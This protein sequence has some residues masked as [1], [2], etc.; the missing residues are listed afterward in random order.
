MDY[1]TQITKVVLSDSAS[2]ELSAHTY[3]RVQ[4]WLQTWTAPANFPAVLTQTLDSGIYACRRSLRDKLL[5]EFISSLGVRPDHFK[6][7]VSQQ[8][9]TNNEFWMSSRVVNCILYEVGK[10]PSYMKA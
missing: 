6:F 9:I 4:D 7:Q 2:H 5:P 10:D 1:V 8:L 3:K